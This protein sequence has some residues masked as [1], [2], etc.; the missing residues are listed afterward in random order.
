[1]RN[2]PE[3]DGGD[4]HGADEPLHASKFV[5]HRS[6]GY[7]DGSL[8]GLECDKEQ[9]PNQDKGD[10]TNREGDEEP[11]TPARLGSHVFESNDIL[12]RGNGRCRAANVGRKGNPK[13][14]R[15]GKARIGRKIAEQGLE[16]TVR[17]PPCHR[18]RT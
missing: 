4:C 5:L 8:P 16:S 3:S 13:D 7:Y 14:K 17:K 11:S 10:D 9:N 2:A 12:G 15:F 18:Y 1:M 6:D